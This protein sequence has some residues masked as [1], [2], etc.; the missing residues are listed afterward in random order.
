[1]VKIRSILTI[2]LFF[3]LFNSNASASFKLGK[4]GP[5][6]SGFAETAI[7]FKFGTDT[8]L[9]D[10]YN[11]MEERFQL[12]TK[13]YPEF[14][15]ILS[16]YM[17]EI[18]F[19]GDMLIDGY[20]EA[21]V[22]FDLRELNLALSPTG[23]LDLKIG[24][25]V[26][27][28]GTGD[29]LFV[30]DLFP[31]DYISFYIGREDEYL[32]K[33][34][35]GA[36]L[37]LYSK[38]INF[39]IV[40]IPFFEPNTIFTGERLSFFDSFRQSISG[41]ESN[42]SLIEP[43]QEIDNIE[44]AT[45]LYRNFGS[46]EG[47]LY[48]FRGFYKLPRGYLNEAEKQLLYPRLDVYGGSV[49]G[50]VLGG[51]GNIELGFYDSKEDS[52]GDERLIENSAVKYLL[53]YSKDLGN[54]F[55]IGLQYFHEQMLDYD[56]YKASLMQGEFNRDEHRHLFTLRATKLLKSQT[57]RANIF[58]FYSPSEK[59]TYLRPSIHYNLTDDFNISIDAKLAL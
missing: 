22:N 13:W 52:S 21:E 11:M 46:I 44:F 26:F 49:R 33:P 41:I 23:W 38:N 53:G 56:E 16:D 55:S 50:P 9:H 45:R 51:I 36:K 7:G 12:K 39:D 15:D 35:D 31:K 32:K 47:A 54:D 4:N 17:A 2:L 29:Y 37:S 58:L 57:V 18:A 40:L 10:D 5:S 42:R 27:T 24:R 59:D 25:Q 14:M 8:T 20:D 6:V 48:T 3:T 30:N 43:N 1:M 34:N 28:W 19:K